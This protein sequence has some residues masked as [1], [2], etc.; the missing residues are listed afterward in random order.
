MVKKFETI[1]FTMKRTT[2]VKKNPKTK[3]QGIVAA[4]AIAI[5]SAVM[6]SVWQIPQATAS[7]LEEIKVSR[8]IY[9]PIDQVWNVISAIDNETRYWSTFKA[10]KNINMT[11]INMT[12]NTTE[13]E[14]TIATGPFGE[15]ITHQFVTVNPEKFVV[16][17]N[18]T[19]G[20]VTGT[21]TL[22]LSPSSSN[23]NATRIDAFWN[24]DMSGI[25]IFG[26]GFAKEGIMR[27]T[28]EALNNIAAEVEVR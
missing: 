7:S 6:S 1:Y 28:E 22:T 21:R 10:I 20:P 3:T 23:S 4:V 5:A 24:V 8:E 25:P 14:V 15:T 27:T 19:Q 16:E 12:A 18:I 9:A 17:T 2:N 26:R 13:R 11:A